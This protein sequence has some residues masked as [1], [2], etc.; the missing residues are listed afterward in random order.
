MKSMIHIHEEV[1]QAL[2]EGKPVV[3][4]ESTII[5]HGMPFPENIQMAKEVGAIIRGNGAVPAT[6]AC[7]NGKL[8][9][10]L[11][12][13]QLKL[14]AES[15]NVMKVSRR[16]LPYAIAMKKIAATTVSATMIGAEMAGIKVFVTGGIG[17]VHR[18]WADSLDI[19]TDLIELAQTNVAVVSAGAKAILDIPATLELLETLGVPVISYRSSRFG[20]FYSSES[21]ET[22]EMRMDRVE[23]IASFLN[24]K[25]ELGLKGGA[26][27]SNPI[28][29]PYEIESNKI[30]T[31]IEDAISKSKDYGIKGKK[32]TPFLLSEIKS[33]TEGRSLEANIQLVKNNARLGAEI[34]AAM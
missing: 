26:L 12:D 16:E 1:R 24:T 4:L 15:D 8:H 21:N 13:Q 2:R 20:A 18:G 14:L 32:L 10:G 31:I 34:A 7:M 28:P 3:A 19:S 23:E 11:D 33:I 25:W 6:I 27:I 30:D 29:K 9:I 5:A 22:V 17:G